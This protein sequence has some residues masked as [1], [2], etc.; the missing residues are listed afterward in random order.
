MPM[1]LM[2]R[3][4]AARLPRHLEASGFVLIKKPPAAQPSCGR[5]RPQPGHIS[6]S[7]PRR[8][9]EPLWT[10]H[11]TNGLPFIVQRNGLAI[12]VLK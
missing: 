8:K 7:T 3:V 11:A 12:V 1:T 2:G 4:T 10:S 5:I 6:P 9:S